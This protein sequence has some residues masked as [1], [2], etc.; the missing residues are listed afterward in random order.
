M[1]N[2]LG[3]KYQDYQLMLLLRRHA[4]QTQHIYTK[5]SLPEG[6]FKH[7]FAELQLLFNHFFITL[8]PATTRCFNGFCMHAKKEG[9]AKDGVYK[10]R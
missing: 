5:N 8:S 6:H 9:F 2:V 4:S 7:L 10:V 3:K 1:E